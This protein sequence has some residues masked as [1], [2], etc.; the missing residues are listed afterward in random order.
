LPTSNVT[1]DSAL[2]PGG[3]LI[4][5]SLLTGT[6]GALG[7]GSNATGQ[8]AASCTLQGSNLNGLAVA[9]S[10]EAADVGFKQVL[11]I[12]GM[13]SGNTPTLTLEQTVD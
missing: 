10:K 11:R 3:S 12:T 1:Y 8:V 2:V 6:N 5:N 13:P 7:A 4:P 9:A